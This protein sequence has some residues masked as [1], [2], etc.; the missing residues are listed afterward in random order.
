M[1][2]IPGTGSVR[3]PEPVVAPPPKA[4]PKEEA[5][6]PMKVTNV[7]DLKKPAPE[8]TNSVPEIPDEWYNTLIAWM[9]FGGVIGVLCAILGLLHSQFF[10]LAPLGPLIGTVAWFV[11]K[12]THKYG[13]K[14]D[15][16]N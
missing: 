6:L 3:K 9:G 16:L 5:A 8:P 2:D 15:V 13:K 14:M 10:Y 1:T 4:A 7:A 11:R 12:A